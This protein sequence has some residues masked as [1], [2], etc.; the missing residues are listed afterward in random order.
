[1]EENN[2]CDGVFGLFSL[3]PLH[4]H[5]LDYDSYFINS[6]TPLMPVILS[7]RPRPARGLRA[8]TAPAIAMS[9]ELAYSKAPP[10][11]AISLSSTPRLMSPIELA[12]SAVSARI[13][14]FLPQSS[15]SRPQ[16]NR[17]SCTPFPRR[18]SK[19]YPTPLHRRRPS[20]RSSCH[21]EPAP[22]HA[23]DQLPWITAL[24]AAPPDHFDIWDIA[25]LSQLPDPPTS[26]CSNPALV[27]RRKT[28]PRATELI[29]S[30]PLLHLTSSLSERRSNTPLCDTSVPSPAPVRVDTS[31]PHT[32]RPRFNPSRVLFHH[33]MPV[34]RDPHNDESE[35][36]TFT[37]LHLR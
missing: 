32:P 14:P 30:S 8:N 24:D 26:N 1:M 27:R 16:I 5:C 13:P 34:L 4:H 2:G 7:P 3:L 22:I 11:A 23:F 21:P 29:P 33:L 37:P 19:P 36:C 28:S 10:R 6:L 18:R 20:S 31:R 25:D 15:R 35:H 17:S 12:P 9:R